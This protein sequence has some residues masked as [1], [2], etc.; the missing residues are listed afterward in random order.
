MSIVHTAIRVAAA[1]LCV[2][3]WGMYIACRH[4]CGDVK[5][6]AMLSA[7]LLAVDVI[8]TLRERA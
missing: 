3:A 6:V 5:Y 1:G 8:L 4:I 2:A 7:C